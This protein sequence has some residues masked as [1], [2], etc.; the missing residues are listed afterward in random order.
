MPWSP[1]P[2]PPCGGSGGEPCAL[3]ASHAEHT[4]WPASNREAR[5]YAVSNSAR[6]GARQSNCRA[7]YH[8]PASNREAPAGAAPIAARRCVLKPPISEHINSRQL[9]T[10]EA[11][12]GAVPIAAHKINQYLSPSPF[13]LRRK[14]SLSLFHLR[15]RR[16]VSAHVEI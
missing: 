15:K 6:R 3:H 10:V 5:P 12:A 7:N 13:S 11:P 4:N 9:A 14:P 8:L 2:P 1:H 16:Y